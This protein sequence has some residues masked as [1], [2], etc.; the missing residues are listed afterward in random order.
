MAGSLAVPPT[1]TRSGMTARAVEATGAGHRGRCRAQ[2]TGVRSVNLTLDAYASGSDYV[3]M[4]K[5]TTIEIDEA[6]LRDG[7]AP[8]SSS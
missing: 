2:G 4:P 6:L 7:A 8:A 1:S 5:R 3:L